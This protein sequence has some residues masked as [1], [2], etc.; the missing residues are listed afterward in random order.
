L[1][2]A[3]QEYAA[4]AAL[5]PEFA[6]ARA[7]LTRVDRRLAA[8]RFDQLMTRGLAHLQRSDWSGA[9]RSFSAALKTRPG[10][11]SAADGL[12]RAKEGLQ[13]DTLAR[14]QREARDLEAAE[15]WE[16]ARAA[17]RRAEAI[18]PTIDFARQGIA[19]SSRMI[20]FRAR[21]DGYL[22]EPQRLYSASVRDEA[23][24]FLAALD[25]ETAGGPRLAEGKRRLETALKRATTKITVRLASD[26]ATEVTLYRV[27]RLGRFQERAV[28]L[29][30]GT[31]TLVGSRPGYRDVRVELVVAP[32]SDPPRVFIA[33]EERV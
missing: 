24:Q 30:P 7:A 4:A 31:Y 32:D 33:C 27:G 6:P 21:I 2:P 12:A 22:V 26:N 18:D 19:R 3:R 15:R 28:T 1:E 9:E 25:N 13:R 20:A 29:T 16:E 10:H 8:Q 17:Y 14:L 11:P 23:R 5:D